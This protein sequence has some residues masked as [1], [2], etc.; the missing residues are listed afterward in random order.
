MA[1]TEIHRE[2]YPYSEDDVGRLGRALLKKTIHLP[3][4]IK[5]NVAVNEREV[6]L[7]ELTQAIQNKTNRNPFDMEKEIQN[8]EKSSRNYELY[9]GDSL[10]SLY[11]IAPDHIMKY[12]LHITKRANGN[13]K[14]FTSEQL[15]FMGDLS[16][17]G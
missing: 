3:F 16:Y 6:T 13:Y 15:W 14:V 11:I 7:E 10:P 1:E 5:F 17:Y 9:Y 2:N 8:L 4:G 12:Y